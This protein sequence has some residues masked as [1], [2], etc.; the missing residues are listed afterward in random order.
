[1]AIDFYLVKLLVGREGVAGAPL[2]HV[3]GGVDAPRG[4]ITGKGEITQ[5][6]EPP[7]GELWINDLHGTVEQF[8]IEPD[9][10]RVVKLTGTFIRYFPPPQIGQVTEEFSATLLIGESSWDG[11]GTFT[12]GRAK[13]ENVPVRELKTGE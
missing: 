5:A 9:P 7:E 12:Y 3:F 13:I 11:I 8:P 4:Q 1:M 2:L 10:L 6:I